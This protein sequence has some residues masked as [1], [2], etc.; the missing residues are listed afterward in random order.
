MQINR[1]RFKQNG[2]CGYVL[3][4]AVM[5]EEGAVF[6]CFQATTFKSRVKTL[7]VSVSV[8]IDVS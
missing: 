6:N 8:D 5:N 4:P 2:D 1:G 3:K 7:K